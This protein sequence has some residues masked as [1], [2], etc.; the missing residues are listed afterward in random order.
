MDKEQALEWDEAQD[1]VISVDLVA[2]AKQQLRFLATVDRNRHLYDGPA[3]DRAIYRYKYCWLPLLAKHAESQV[4]EGPLVVPLDCE[5]I[6]HCHRLNPVRY[7]SDCE[8]FYGRIL[9]N[10]D[11]VSSVQGTSGK[12]TEAIWNRLY[13]N[14][15]YELD[16]SSHLLD[17]ADNILGAPESTKYD[18]VSAVKR[19]SPFFYQVSR[20]SMNDGHFLEEAVA[21][22]KGFL[23]L[24]KR[25]WER[26]IKHFGVPTYDIDLIWHSHQL[27]PVSYCKDLVAILGK[28]LEHDDMDSDRAKGKMLDV[29]FSG[30]TKQ[31]EDTFG[32]RNWRAG[33][34]NRG[35]AP[36]L[37][38]TNLRPLNTVRNKGFASTEYQN[39]I[40]L[41]KTM[42]VE[43]V[44]ME[45]VEVKNS[46]NGHKGSLFVSFSKTDPD[47]LLSTRRRLSISSESGEKRVAAFRCVP[48]GELLVE[49]MSCSPS[50]LPIVRPAE[51]LGTTLISLE[52]LLNPVSTFSIEKWF[53][54]VPSSGIVSSKP[55]SL[56][57]ALSFTPP[58]L[59][60]YALQLVWT[61]PFSSS[62]CFNPLT[63][64][65]QHAKSWTRVVD[66]AGNEVISIQMRD[67]KKAETRNNCLLKKE[68]IGMTRYC[69]TCVLA[70]FVG[71]GWWLMD[72]QWFFQLQK[73][74]SE[75]D[76][77]FE[78]TGS[79]KLIYVLLFS[80]SR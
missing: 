31:W 61:Y 52:N 26:S 72:S 54:L 70:E 41:P 4:S 3:L 17:V 48:N 10:W 58:V 36:S 40:Q 18:L 56:R 13:P 53:E 73:T 55:I 76:H 42:L 20:P 66:E 8:E 22:Y 43:V 60:P 35:S 74:F 14:E 57:I 44:M 46:P 45:I 6:W 19:Q 28:I 27:H 67:S 78:L 69:E 9:D 34:M 33:A 37:L 49:L 25:N 62:S 38:P 7:K 11:V 15:P 50:H 30:T 71:T 80:C 51:I 23:H 65:V 39:M 2:A 29:G 63:G 68:V 16:L 75:D 1:I 32:S 77:I 24:I 59:A 21:R 12:Q 64:K 47:M 79:R 5:W